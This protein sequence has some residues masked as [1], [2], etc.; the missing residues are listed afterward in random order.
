MMP[1]LMLVRGFQSGG[2]W[3]SAV[4][5]HVVMRG[6][7]AIADYAEFVAGIGLEANEI[8]AVVVEVRDRKV[9]FS[10]VFAFLDV[11]TA[12][13]LLPRLCTDLTW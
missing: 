2:D 5:T 4:E 12:F 9:I 6:P 7:T 13:V 10:R 3:A 8:I 1:Y 11:Q